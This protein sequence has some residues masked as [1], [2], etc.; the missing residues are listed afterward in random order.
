MDYLYVISGEKNRYPML[1]GAECEMLNIR[2]SPTLGC[3]REA[4]M[5]CKATSAPLGRMI[6]FGG[7]IAF[8]AGLSLK[9]ASN[10]Y[11]GDFTPPQRGLSSSS[12]YRYFPI[13]GTNVREIVN[14][15]NRNG[16]LVRG[17]KAWGLATM[18]VRYRIYTRRDGRRCATQ[19]INME[20]SYLITLPR[21][22][23]ETRIAPGWAKCLHELYE[24]MLG[25]SSDSCRGLIRDI[26]NLYSA[27]I[28][29]CTKLQNDFDRESLKISARQP[30]L[31]ALTRSVQKKED[32]WKNYDVPLA[33]PGE[34]AP[35]R[36][37]GCMAA[38]H[39]VAPPCGKPPA[40]IENS[41]VPG[42]SVRLL[43]AGP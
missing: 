14:S 23:D 27:K 21:H 39:G 40:L 33:I 5:K 2:V 37:N 32:V 20:V 31:M 4:D 22:R 34:P 8:L 1:D 35:N 12:E 9:A 25:L 28:A 26:Q 38:M 13:G 18:Q 41:L 6:R 16:P 43:C 15:L 42:A 30:M 3:I 17:K 29:A 10:V 11:A 24:N 36:K 19:K 7:L